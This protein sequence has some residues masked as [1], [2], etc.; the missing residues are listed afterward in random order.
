MAAVFTDMQAIESPKECK[1]VHA[2][3]SMISGVK[4]PKYGV[5]SELDDGNGNGCDFLS[6]CHK[7]V[8]S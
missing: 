5:G 2:K 6:C 1:Q 7:M 4:A 3:V 8:F